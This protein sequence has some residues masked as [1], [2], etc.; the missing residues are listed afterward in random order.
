MAFPLVSIISVN[1][2]QTAVTGA[3][4]ESIQHLRYPNIEV[5]LVDNGSAE[6]PGDWVAEH[7]PDVRYL[8]T[9]KNL[10]FSGGNNVG[11][12][13]ARGEFF[14]LVNNDTELT[15]DL[16][17]RL[18]EHFQSD[19]TIGMVCPLIRYF[20]E[21]KPIQ[22]AG[23][24]PMHPI[25]ARNRTIG[26][27]SIDQGQY[28]VPMETAFA[29]GAAM[30]TSRAVVDRAGLM[31][32]LYFLY[33]EELDWSAA[34]LRAGFRLSV[35]PRAVI[36]HKES[37]SVGRASPLKTYYMSRN[38]V[39]FMRRNAAWWSWILFLVYWMLV[40]APVHSLRYWRSGQRDHLRAFWRAMAWHLQSKRTRE[41][42]PAVPA[43]LLPKGA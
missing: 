21:P 15:P 35:E 14:L 33:Y 2:N 41:A 22:F 10:G 17:D 29:H 37:V 43:F 36:F 16:V 26:Q 13:A 7:F 31:P 6:P 3:F 25:T 28:T 12:R 8:E 40:V 19:P 23:Y 38:R 24:T 5:I 20:D 27:N 18:L 34:I 4:L 42:P 39:L 11:L 30:F 9:G 1:F 32:E